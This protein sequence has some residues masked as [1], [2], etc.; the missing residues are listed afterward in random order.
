MSE[1]I[2]AIRAERH[3]P[4][5]EIQTFKNI[6]LHI[7]YYGLLLKLLLFSLSTF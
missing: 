3:A 1:I 2:F 6:Y 5:A 4:V 7:V